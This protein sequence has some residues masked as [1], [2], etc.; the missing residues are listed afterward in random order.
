MCENNFAHM[1]LHV[2]VSRAHNLARRVIIDL[3]AHNSLIQMTQRLFS[4]R[5]A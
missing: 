2:I 5:F 4:M 3:P 1:R